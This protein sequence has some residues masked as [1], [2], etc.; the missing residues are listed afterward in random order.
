MS[1]SRVDEATV[2]FRRVLAD[3]SS[4]EQ[5]RVDALVA[6][7]QRMVFVATWPGPN[8][9]ARTLTNSHG[10]SALPLF[11][12]LDVLEGTATRF[13]WRNPDGSLQ[14]RE[15]G[16]RE[17]L[18]HAIARNVHF[19]VVDMGCEHSVEF[20]RE[21]LEPLLAQQP[22]NPAGPQASAQDRQAAVLEAVRRNSQRPPRAPL[23]TGPSPTLSGPALAPGRVPTIT[24]ASP[25]LGA[26][27]PS[28]SISG[29]SRTITAPSAT[30]TGP[31]PTISGP[32]PIQS[33]QRRAASR[34]LSHDLP[35]P[36]ATAARRT[37]V[38][39]LRTQTSDVAQGAQQP[40]QPRVRPPSAD[41]GGRP[42]E[43]KE[44]RGRGDEPTL[45]ERASRPLILPEGLDDTV[46]QAL[47][48]ELR[49]FPEVEWACVLSDGSDLPVIAVRIDPSFLN[50]VT[51]I[52]DVIMDVG[53]Q[54]SLSLQVLLLNTQDLV[55]RARRNGHAFYPWKR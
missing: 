46:L 32:V 16:A 8:Q 41:F 2:A 29:P 44:P 1:A 27:A 40:T 14:F 6:L 33:P 15:L 47:G 12:A 24:G 55:K 7:V 5:A 22:A 18:R 39:A 23:P 13:G 3:A 54:Q 42:P 43:P 10:E 28:P 36:A 20:A 48:V 53:E 35:P 17:A 31:S 49:A 50:R 52:T 9:A 38:P 26:S 37:P 45:S 25:I 34:Q 30:I 11:T 4:G 21:E 19:V 51:D